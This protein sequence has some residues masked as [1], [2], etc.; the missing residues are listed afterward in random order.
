MSANTPVRIAI[1]GASGW[2]GRELLATRPA[3]A[4]V[5]AIAR[6]PIAVPT[7]V[8]LRAPVDLEDAEQLN[9]AL[10]DIDLVIH[11]AD[12]ADRTH[13]P[14]AALLG[15]VLDA[16]RANGVRRV[17]YA[18]SIFA[19]QPET[20]RN[21]YGSAKRAGERLAIASDLLTVGVRL[22]PVY[23]PQ[24]R[25][26][27]GLLV[28]AIARGIPLPFGCATAPRSYLSL[29]NAADLFWKIACADE[30]IWVAAG[31]AVFEPD[32]GA[33]LS[34]RDLAQAIGKAM[35]RPAR[36]LPVPR[37]LLAAVPGD[38]AARIV[39]AAFDP[40]VSEGNAPIAAAF[41]WKP[42]QSFA[43]GLARAVM[44]AQ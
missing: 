22:P 5:V 43:E 38:A 41:D 42:S 35:G 1:T 31:N 3:G 21:W 44:P 26:S 23:G 34:T 19:K 14:G 25:G 16:A 10:C 37:A 8:V 39:G 4:Q 33:V 7:G 6:R 28:R 24:S 40:L 29:R 32:D 20:P 12:Q 36:L 15:H 27:F 18:S 13:A 9:A 11:L 17:A 2:I 30:A